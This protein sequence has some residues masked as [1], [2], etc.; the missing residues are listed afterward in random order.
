MFEHDAHVGGLAKDA[1]VRQYA[2]VDEVVGAVPVTAVFLA[3]EFTPLR[4]FDFAGN[5]SDD[6][7]ALQAYAGVLQRSHGIGVANKRA[8]HVVDA[9]AVNESVFDNG[10]WLVAKAGEKFLVASVGSIHVAVE[11]QIPAG[12]S[13]SPAA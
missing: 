7:V 1:H 13:A 3:F 8:F 10:M 4:L 6:D 11:H 2:V 12:A 9:E 5:G